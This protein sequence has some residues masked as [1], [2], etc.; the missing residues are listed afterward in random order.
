MCLYICVGCILHVCLRDILKCLNLFHLACFDQCDSSVVLLYFV[1]RREHTALSWGEGWGC[2]DGGAKGL[3]VI[4]IC[5]RR[6]QN[7]PASHTLADKHIYDPCLHLRRLE[8]CDRFVARPRVFWGKGLYQHLDLFQLPV[9]FPIF[10]PVLLDEGCG[11]MAGMPLHL[12][13]SDQM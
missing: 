11:K 13:F 7:K 6:E 8:K 3:A 9:D 2:G 4:A 12:S 1:P 5:R 10:F